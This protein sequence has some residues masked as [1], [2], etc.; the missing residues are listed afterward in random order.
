MS[1]F[2]TTTPLGIWFESGDELAFSIEHHYEFIDEDYTMF[3]DTAIAR[4]GYE[5]RNFEI[6]YESV[7]SR[8]LSFD[9]SHE[10]GEYYNGKRKLYGAAVTVKFNRFLSAGP[11]YEYNDIII[12]DDTF[13][14]RE[15]GLRIRG[16]ISTKLTSSTFIQ[17][18]NESHETNL[19][20]RIHYIPAI[21]SDLYIVYNQ[22][23]DEEDDYRT[24]SNTGIFKADYLFRF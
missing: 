10:W 21:G 8:M 23:W 1:G 19:N 18:N 16:N 22:L 17:W 12:G 7:K 6:E 9:F 2:S 14:A 4:D 20:F 24:L 3:D 13:T 15:A 11:E 5:W